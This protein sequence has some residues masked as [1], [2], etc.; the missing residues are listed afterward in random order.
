M[1]QSK[2]INTHT[3][4]VVIFSESRLLVT[5]DNSYLFNVTQFTKKFAD[6]SI[7]KTIPIKKE[8]ECDS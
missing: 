8:E 2:E 5:I 4:R 7:F 3:G 6:L 1:D